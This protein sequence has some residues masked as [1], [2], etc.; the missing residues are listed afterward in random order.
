LVLSIAFFGDE[1]RQLRPDAFVV[2]QLSACVPLL[3]WLCSDRHRTLFYCHF[4][5][6]LLADRKEL[7]IKGLLKSIYRIP[8]DWFEGW[9][10]AASDKIV[11][12]SKFTQGV[13]SKIIPA[14]GPLTVI[15][16]CVD[17]SPPALDVT[18]KLLWDGK[19]KI[20]VSINRF[21]RKK[22]IGLAIKA[23]Q[24][25]SVEE[26]K[27]KRLVLAGGYDNRVAENVE[28]HQELV[29]M[30]EKMGLR[31]ATARTVT[32]ALGIPDEVQVLFM[33][34]VPGSFKTTLLQQST[35]LIY[36][37]VNEHFGIVPVEAMQAGLP[38][39][40]SNTGGPLETVI[41]GK[42][43]WLRDASKPEQWTDVVR[44]V[45]R[46]DAQLLQRMGEAG[47]KRVQDNFT[48][49]TMA[50]KFQDEIKA[51]IGA[52]RSEFIDGTQILMAMGLVAAFAAALLATII[53]A[54]A[55]RPADKRTTEFVKA[56]RVL[57]GKEADRDFF[58]GRIA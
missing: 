32:T 47:R 56:K 31:T 6:Q 38:V 2:D 11:V 19:F 13:A 27:G 10:T 20:I 58:A 43:G 1:L 44:L 37:P 45:L 46:S 51:M 50:N 33:L 15:Y 12:N 30:A 25:L 36:T 49:S 34:S 28:Y 14:K 4:P 35:I 55:G 40:A 8:F 23:F 21:E 16:P 24:G 57:T 39:L 48:R 41:D 18:G 42:T 52:P 26:S 53:N 5:D 3:R 7:G 29:E 17:S 9:S 22:D 54:S